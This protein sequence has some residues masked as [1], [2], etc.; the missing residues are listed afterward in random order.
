MSNHLV[1]ETSPYLLQHADNPVDWYPWGKEAL[2]R[3]RSQNKPILLSIGY[4]A[5]H[6][7]HVMAHECF[8]DDDVAAM[9][10]QYFVNIKVDREERPDLDHIYQTAHYMLNQRNGGWPLTLFLT[11]EQQPFFGGTYF[12]K[13]PRYE[14]PGFLDLLPRVAKTYMV[15]GKAIAQQSAEL[16]KLLADTRPS[17]SSVAPVFTGSLFNQALHELKDMLDPV[18][19]GF[20]QAPKFIHPAEIGFCLRQY[21]LTK[22]NDALKIAELTLEKMARGGIHDQI[23]G[24]F[25]R[26]STDQRWQIPHFEKMLYDN[27]SLL[28][29]YTDAWLATGN[30]L[31]KKT[32]AE[33]AE[34]VRREMQS[35]LGTA[36][37][38]YAALDADSEH[39]EGKFYVWS[40]DQIA[41]IVSQEEFAVISPY[42]GLSQEP[43]FEREYW[44]LEI[45]EPLTKVAQLACVSVEEAQQRLASAR[46]KLF[47]ARELRVHPGR[48]DKILTGWN[49]LMIKGM[50]NAGRVFERDD[51]IDSAIRA[52][53][54]I[55]AT[56]WK[57][58][59][60]LVTYKD[61]SAR[62]NAY[63]DDYAFLLD[64]LLALMQKEFRAVDLEFAEALAE[65]LLD[66]FEDKAAGGF[67]FTSHDHEKLIHRPMP[68]HDNAMPSG[69]G[70]AVVAL[71]R[72]GHLLGNARYLQAAERALH[73]FYPVI[74]RQPSASCTFLTAIDEII[75]P[76]QIVILR[77]YE[78]DLSK[79]RREMQSKFPQ[80]FVITLSS[81]LIGLSPSLNRALP[82]DGTVNAW[83]CQ[84]VNC[85]PEI[86]NIQELLHVCEDQGKISSLL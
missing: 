31:F 7:C 46:D 43:N 47:S 55:R 10:N 73:L 71:Q 4:S 17:K 21:F 82:T 37:G 58:N 75:V 13:Q 27:G 33:T 48:D 14:L 19:G 52:V 61:G 38:Y 51:W 39:E 44:N 76:P 6:W 26:Y 83:V 35:P 56:L 42:Y 15:R 5:C 30:A 32:A 68:I 81:E 69:N 70:L 34:W 3:A 77:G 24:G 28:Q 12:P 45:V 11:P 54:F 85:L 60:L 78:P 9:M 67:F 49:G 36:G 50:V 8:E 40:R 84:G 66:Q 53:D 25:Y 72:I 64:S 22:N 59:R 57:N 41:Q 29:L 65:V 74:A 79:W 1:N 63:L 16:Q 23:G 2:L 86:S 18:Y 20:G 80:L 62:L